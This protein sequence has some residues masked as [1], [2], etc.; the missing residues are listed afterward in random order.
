MSLPSSCSDAGSDQ[1]TTNKRW[2]SAWRIEVGARI[3]MLLSNC[4]HHVGGVDEGDARQ[5]RERERTDSR[6]SSCLCTL[7]PASISLITSRQKWQSSPCGRHYSSAVQQTTHPPHF[8][9]LTKPTFSHSTDATSKTHSTGVFEETSG[10][11]VPS[12]FEQNLRGT[13]ILPIQ[14]SWGEF[15]NRQRR[16]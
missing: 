16:N 13:V 2:E 11:I 6:P 3:R 12:R 1:Q 9:P 8:Q 14:E 5:E 4:H 7:Y 15:S 10:V